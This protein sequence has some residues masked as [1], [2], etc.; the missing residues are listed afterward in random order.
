MSEPKPPTGEQPMKFILFVSG[1]ASRMWPLSRKDRPKAFAQPNPLGGQESVFQHMVGYLLDG[2][3]SASDIFV[4][5]SAQHWHF[6]RE[7][8]PAIPEDQIILEPAVRDNAAAVGLATTMVDHRYPG[9]TIAL[10]WASDHYMAKPENF[11]ASLK[12]AEQIVRDHNLIVQINVRPPAAHTHVGYVEIGQPIL[13]AY[14]SSIYAFKKHVEKPDLTTARRYYRE[15]TWLIHTGY[16]VCRADTLLDL[17]RQHAPDLYQPLMDIKAALDS[18][19]WP[20]VI[21]QVYPQLR[22]VSIDTAVHEKTLPEGQAVIEAD[23]GWKDPGDFGTIY[24]EMP[25]DQAGVAIA[26]Q[27]DVLIHDSHNSL[28]M[29]PKGTAVALVGLE[30]VAVVVTKDGVLVMHKDRAA[31]VKKI[32]AELNEQGLD[33]YL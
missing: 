26:G 19:N 18:S 9:A 33:K 28:V 12:T 1:A 20:E 21:E 3:F 23:L 31:D 6:V 15:G 5:T 13:P 22:K 16:R 2:G 32:V 27:A 30:D 8:A 11:V 25:K 10:I 17:Y 24:L 14:N 29:G 7:Q 4:A